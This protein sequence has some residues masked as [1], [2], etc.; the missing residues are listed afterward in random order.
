MTQVY[1]DSVWRKAKQQTHLQTNQCSA[2]LKVKGWNLC[3][4]V[5][6]ALWFIIYSSAN[7]EASPH[8][9]SGLSC[10]ICILIHKLSGISDWQHL[11]I[12]EQAGVD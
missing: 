8:R 5:G 12:K 7:N 2:S 3:I 9:F 6:Q 4:G 11:S 1:A 10:L